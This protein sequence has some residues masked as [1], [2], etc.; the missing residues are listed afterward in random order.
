MTMKFL[1]YLGNVVYV[2]FSDFVGFI[3]DNHGAEVKIV[4]PPS[5]VL[6]FTILLDIYS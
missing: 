5:G 2:V 4:I 3:I 1:L 6:H